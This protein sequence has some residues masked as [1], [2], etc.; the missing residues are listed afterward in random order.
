[1]TKKELSAGRAGDILLGG[2]ISA[3]RLGFRAMCLTG[4]GIWGP[5]KD[6]R[7]ALAVLRPAV[8][9]DINFID[10]ADSYGHT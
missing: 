8:E 10:T 3:H 2:E 5:P 1:M 4:E 9:L 7:G 6:R